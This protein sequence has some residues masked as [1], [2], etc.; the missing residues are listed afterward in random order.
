MKQKRPLLMYPIIA[1]Y[2]LVGIFYF[3]SGFIMSGIIIPFMNFLTGNNLP[4]EQELFK[5]LVKFSDPFAERVFTYTNLILQGADMYVGIVIFSGSFV[6][7]ATFFGLIKRIKLAMF[8]AIIFSL[9]QISYGFYLLTLGDVFNFLYHLFF[10]ISFITILV[11][12]SNKY[13]T[14]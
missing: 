10:H 2:F 9:I 5:F 11:I 6:L 12:Y 1:Y 14:R 8:I 3:V 7:F 4:I 13:F